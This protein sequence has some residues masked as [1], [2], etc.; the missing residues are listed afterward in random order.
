MTCQ[1]YENHS[2]ICRQYKVLVMAKWLD[3]NSRK[4]NMFMNILHSWF[5]ANILY[6]RNN[7]TSNK[8]SDFWSLNFSRFDK[9]F[10][11]LHCFIILLFDTRTILIYE[12]I[13]VLLQFSNEKTD[14][15]LLQW[16]N[17]P[18]NYTTLCSLASSDGYRSTTPH[19]LEISLNEHVHTGWNQVLQTHQQMAVTTTYEGP[20]L[21]SVLRTNS[22]AIYEVFG[23]TSLS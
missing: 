22:V 5:Y 6:L 11:C 13:L 15:R 19:S 8:I 21:T 14:F 17:S 3:F 12:K 7:N 1:K 9:R 4:I 2:F 23:C 18:V 10:E 16:L 20:R